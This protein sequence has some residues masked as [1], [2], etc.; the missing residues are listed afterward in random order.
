MEGQ[1]V[2][3]FLRQLG[4]GGTNNNFRTGVEGVRNPALDAF[5]NDGGFLGF[6]GQSPP[7][8]IG[9]GTMN[10]P[11]LIEAA[12]TGPFF[13]TDTQIINA[14]AENTSSAQTIEQAV[15]FYNSQAFFL[16]IDA[17]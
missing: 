16:P 8:A 7:G 12:D 1:A 5:P 15:A 17:T 3:T 9:D 2:A 6:A 4:F 11:S 14:P 13:H 10:T